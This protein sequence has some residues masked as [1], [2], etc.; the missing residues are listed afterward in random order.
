[1]DRPPPDGYIWAE[2]GIGIVLIDP[3]VCPAGHPID[4][5]RRGWTPCSEHSGHTVWYC[6]CGQEIYRESGAF[7]AGPPPCS[8]SERMPPL[9]G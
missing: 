5:F 1:M 7:V 3:L 6:S 9:G 2:D 8:R 4:G